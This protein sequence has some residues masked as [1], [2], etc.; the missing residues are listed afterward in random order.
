MNLEGQVRE[1]NLNPKNAC[2]KRRPELPEGMAGALAGAFDQAQSRAQQGGGGG[3][4][5]PQVSLIYSSQNIDTI[6]LMIV[7]FHFSSEFNYIPK[8]NL[9]FKLQKRY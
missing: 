5:E 7:L 1:R 2:L 3:E 6:D 4:H 8:C 9:I